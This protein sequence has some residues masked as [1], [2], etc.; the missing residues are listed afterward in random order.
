MTF[1]ADSSRRH[2]FVAKGRLSAAGEDEHL[3]RK[4]SREKYQRDRAEKK[5]VAPF[6]VTLRRR[7]LQHEQ[8]QRRMLE[9]TKR[10]TVTIVKPERRMSDESFTSTFLVDQDPDTAFTAINNVR[11]WWSGDIE[12]DTDKLGG[13]FTYRYEDVHYSK[14]RITEFVPNERVVWQVV[15]SSLSFV[16]NKTEWNGTEI[17]FDVSRSGDQTEV[18]FTHH[19]LVPAYECFEACSGA[20]SYYMKESLRQFISSGQGAPN[21]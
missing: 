6:G 1:T 17:S 11:G 12:G 2:S 20:W 7:S 16:E 14:Q 4:R 18:C 21:Q 5:S 9:P 15:D 10:Q 13:E 8:R 19:G 3:G